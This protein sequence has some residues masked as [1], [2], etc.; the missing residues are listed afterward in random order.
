M[1]NIYQEISKSLNLQMPPS[2]EYLYSLLDKATDILDSEDKSYRPD[3]ND[4][5][6]GAM[7]DFTN[8]KSL[9]TIIIPDIHARTNFIKN[10]REIQVFPRT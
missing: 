1:K 7:L 8:E 4:K 10:I 2:Y 3:A 5:S 6:L 9:P